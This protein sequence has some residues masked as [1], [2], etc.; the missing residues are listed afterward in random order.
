MAKTVKCEICGKEHNVLSETYVRVQGNIYAGGTGG[1]VGDNFPRLGGSDKDADKFRAED[2]NSSYYCW[3]CLIDILQETKARVAE[4]IQ[5]DI[6]TLQSQLSGLL[7]ETNPVEIPD[8][9][10]K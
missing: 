10:N 4:D 2:V 3:N 7:P 9:L 8:F 1:I 6:E 5:K